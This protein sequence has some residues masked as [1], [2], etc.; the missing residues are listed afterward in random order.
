MSAIFGIISDNNLIHETFND[1]MKR[2]DR[3]TFDS[4]DFEQI[5]CVS[6][7]CFHQFLTSESYNEILPYYDEQMNSIITSD[8]ILDNREQLARDLKIII[9]SN[10]SDSELILRA[11]K[12]WGYDCVCH[13]IGDFAFAIYNLS[14]KELFLA[15][16]QVG[17]RS[18]YY[19][20]NESE[21][22]FSTT[23]E[24]LLNDFKLNKSYLQRFLG[25]Q[26]VI[27]DVHETETVY[28]DVY[29]VKPAHYIIY[30]DGKI[31]EKKYWDLK[32]WNKRLSFDQS[33]N[34]FRD[35]FNEVVKDKLR[36]SGEV[37]IMLSGGLDSS[38]VAGVAAPILKEYEKTLYAF[39]TIAQSKYKLESNKYYVVDESFLVESM[40]NKYSNIK[41]FKIESEELNSYNVS[42]EILEIL[43]EPYKFMENGFWLN[44]I[45]RIAK[46]KGCSVLLDGQFGNY[47]FSYTNI[48]RHLRYQFQQLKIISFYNDMT[49]YCKTNSLARKKFI[50]KFFI[51]Y[52]EKNGMTSEDIF[53]S[54]S[55][56]NTENE[57]LITD[58]FRN[59]IIDR[60][61]ISST[62]IE[63]KGFMSSSFLNEYSA[64]E[65]KMGL[66]YNIIKRD[67]TRDIRV[68]E[69]IY[70]MSPE[71]F[72]YKGGDRTL[73]K[74]AFKNILSDEIIENQALG[75]QGADWKHRLLK[76][77]PIM[78][79]D[80]ENDLDSCSILDDIMDVKKF[81]QVLNHYKDI[82]IVEIDVNENSELRSIL[83]VSNVIQ[84]IKQTENKKRNTNHN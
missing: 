71:V 38:S 47:G 45:N 73:P 16:D 18:L 78:I 79:K 67:P 32:K 15:K 55:E 36:T 53:S 24:P 46:T 48:I 65:T 84:F 40:V 9:K 33:I 10:T 7:A 60:K 43:E 37:G 42:Q 50:K 41:A 8:A 14:K 49:A 28:K 6:F 26:I 77:W 82:N 75:L 35:V 5:E 34:K 51:N 61:I 29:H 54:Y 72:N 20:F 23:I 69:C 27:D 66:A 57:K 62:N 13:L 25:I 2:N 64:Y 70:N 81:K 11:Y 4:I 59:A 1:R 83:I 19:F 31:I 80:L 76:D 52:F 44:N 56:M 30:K 17:K 22:S 39:T 21:F 63:M 68:L 74:Y 3:Y 12:K 58:Y